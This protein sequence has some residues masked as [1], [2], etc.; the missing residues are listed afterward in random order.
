MTPEN[1]R[2]ILG[3][4][5]TAKKRE[6]DQAYRE[7]CKVFQLKIRPGNPLVV[8]KQAQAQLVQITEAWNVLNQKPV[9]QSTKPAPKPRTIPHV[10]PHH[11]S[12][13]GGPLNLANVWERVF[14]MMPLPWPVVA[15]VAATVVMG[16]IFL[17]VT[18]M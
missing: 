17:F 13:S 8:R 10:T 11:T 16:V 6:I 1:A 15:A 3:V 5:R 4:P 12:H 14:S 7:R 2:T 18:K 9:K